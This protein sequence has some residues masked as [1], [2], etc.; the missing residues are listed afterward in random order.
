MDLPHPAA[1]PFT[2]RPEHTPPARTPPEKC[3][4]MAG[5]C[6]YQDWRCLSRAL[7]EPTLPME[8][9]HTTPRSKEKKKNILSIFLATPALHYTDVVPEARTRASSPSED[10]MKS[11]MFGI[12]FCKNLAVQSSCYSKSADKNRSVPQTR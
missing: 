11:S 4:R 6:V 10:M 5:V 1:T 9:L 7:R 8:C 3:E 2:N 12:A